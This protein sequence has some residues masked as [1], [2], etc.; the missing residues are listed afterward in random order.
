MP[1]QDGFAANLPC[2]RILLSRIYNAVQ[3]LELGQLEANVMTS[4]LRE[5]LET[6][7][8]RCSSPLLD[9]ISAL[10]A[11]PVVE[12]REDP[13]G[14]TRRM[15]LTVA[16]SEISNFPDFIPKSIAD[17][18]AHSGFCLDLLR[19]FDPNHHFFTEKSSTFQLTVSFNLAETHLI[20]SF[21]ILHIK[22]CL[23][24][25]A[26]R[27]RILKL[28][29]LQEIE[30]RKRQLIQERQKLSEV[31]KQKD[32]ERK[33]KTRKKASWKAQIDIFLSEMAAYR[34]QKEIER[35]SAA[36]ELLS[37]EQK[38]ASRLRAAEEAVRS[39]MTTNFENKMRALELKTLKVEWSLQRNEL[40][41]QRQKVLPDEDFFQIESLQ[42]QNLSVSSPERPVETFTEELLA[43]QDIGV[44]SLNE[45]E[46]PESP[47]PLL[48][49]DSEVDIRPPIEPV[50][51]SP[52][53][54][55]QLTNSP[56]FSPELDITLN[57]ESQPE[58]LQ[59]NSFQ[60]LNE[61]PEESQID[62]VVPA[63]A[64]SIQF[65]EYQPFD[66]NHEKLCSCHGITKYLCPTPSFHFASHGVKKKLEHPLNFAS[67]DLVL[68][69]TMYKAIYSRCDLVSRETL[70]VLM[71]DLKLEDELNMV[72]R[73]FFLFD[74]DFADYV[75][76]TNTS[77]ERQT[78][79]LND[80]S[81]LFGILAE[82]NNPQPKFK[83]V[84]S[85]GLNSTMEFQNSISLL[86]DA[87]SP[88]TFVLSNSALKKL[89]RCFSLLLRT[90][91]C[92]LKIKE[93]CFRQN[94]VSKSF[95]RFKLESTEFVTN[96]YRYFQDIALSPWRMFLASLRSVDVFGFDS[97][98]DTDERK[99]SQPFKITDLRNL[100]QSFDVAL[101]QVCFRMMLSKEQNPVLVLYLDILDNICESF[102]VSSSSETQQVCSLKEKIEVFVKVVDRLRYLDLPSAGLK[103]FAEVGIIGPWDGMGLSFLST[104][105]NFNNYYWKEVKN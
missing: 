73:G 39:E 14:L 103:R 25:L 43:V 7:F 42:S 36:A 18:V 1:N 19:C 15:D 50:F 72:G 59:P 34:A 51:S 61:L 70:F 53:T 76:A 77:D 17:A 2:G 31:V 23:Q 12:T 104:V 95:L 65:K 89:S 96:V 44:Q 92:L 11:L 69:A 80:N 75:V 52:M 101:D 60:Q 6:F 79:F 62:Q 84:K 66:S 68:Q 83:V 54:P 4:I 49:E 10:V 55:K 99:D 64:E 26:N 87:K 16:R 29:K 85:R 56:G 94:G 28:E 22:S 38:D 40:T 30:D 48:K 58:I 100:K 9:T 20:R 74:S 47:T 88:V 41:T 63:A 67:L 97:R 78:V 46:E 24:T 86:Y 98:N 33:K 13:L 21:I 57:P 32:D 5:V 3:N 37:A 91:T 93:F 8:R 81:K 82:L 45:E 102:A 105:V 71:K 35:I 90:R 27:F